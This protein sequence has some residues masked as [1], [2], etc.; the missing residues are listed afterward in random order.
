M[1]K[2]IRNNLRLERRS[3]NPEHKLI[4]ERMIKWHSEP[5]LVRI[6]KPTNLPR[7]RGLGY[8][9]KKGY[10]IT[11]SKVRIGNLRK[12]RPSKGRKPVHQGVL[13]HV[14]KKSLQW[15]AEERAAKHYPNL[16][17]LNSY[18]VGSDAFHKYYEIIMVDPVEPSIVSDPKINWIYGQKNRVLRGL[19]SAGKK[20]RGLR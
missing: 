13:K 7:A 9:A 8:K 19:T 15:I 18:W 17:V 20:A 2:Y 5:S 10:V 6:E 11:R 12:S 3:Q 14:S 4:S 1:Y 16:E